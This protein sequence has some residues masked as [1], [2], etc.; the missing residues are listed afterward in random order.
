MLNLH[1]VFSL[2]KK[3]KLWNYSDFSFSSFSLLYAF[4]E[5]RQSTS[6]NQC[7]KIHPW[8]GTTHFSLSIVTISYRMYGTFFLSFTCFRLKDSSFP[9]LCFPRRNV[10]RERIRPGRWN[11]IPPLSTE[12]R[13]RLPCSIIIRVYT[14]WLFPLPAVFNKVKANSTCEFR[15]ATTALSLTTPWKKNISSCRLNV[16]STNSWLAYTRC[17]RRGI[18]HSVR[19]KHEKKTCTHGKVSSKFNEIQNIIYEI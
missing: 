10:L 18:S 7:S 13:R 11:A 6:N 2:K 9:L 3:N 19:S 17:N 5:L 8:E 16:N 15:I 1:E 4:E 12:Y 14:E